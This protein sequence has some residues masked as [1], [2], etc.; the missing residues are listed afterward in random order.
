MGRGNVGRHASSQSSCL[1]VVAVAGGRRQAAGAAVL[2]WPS[3][4]ARHLGSGVFFSYTMILKQEGEEGKPPC[5]NEAGGI[6]RKT[7]YSQPRGRPL[8]PLLPRPTAVTGRP[9]D[10]IPPGSTSAHSHRGRKLA[11]SCKINSSFLQFKIRKKK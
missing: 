8:P 2:A 4:S 1:E 11:E 10:R 5:H 3:T 9:L 7:R 6:S